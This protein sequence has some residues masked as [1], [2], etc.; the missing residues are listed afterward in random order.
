MLQKMANVLVVGSGMTGAATAAFL[1]QA[2]PE[3][4]NISIWDKARGAGIF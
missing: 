4:T 3:N 1:R 2:L